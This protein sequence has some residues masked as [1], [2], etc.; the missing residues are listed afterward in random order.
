MDYYTTHQV[1]IVLV[2]L[3]G[4]GKS[5]FATA[6]QSFPP[7][8]VRCNQDDLGDRKAVEAEVHKALGAGKS[9]CVDRTNID[10]SQRRTWIEIGRDYPSVE[11]WCVE[12]DMSKEVCL[13]RLETR[14]D[15]PTI[16]DMQTARKVLDQFSSQYKT[17]CLCEGF[18]LVFRLPPDHEVTPGINL[19]NN[20][21][22]EGGSSH[23]STAENAPAA[24]NTPTSHPEI[25]SLSSVGT[26]LNN[27]ATIA[28]HPYRPKRMDGLPPDPRHA[29]AP[30]GSSYNRGGNRSRGYG[31]RGAGRDDTFGNRTG[32]GFPYSRRGLDPNSNAGGGVGRG[33]GFGSNNIGRGNQTTTSSSS[34]GIP[35]SNIGTGDGR[36]GRGGSRGDAD[37][38]RGGG[39]PS[40]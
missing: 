28:R 4:S 29:S 32:R 27:F 23:T 38:G 12:V 35:N 40:S 10:A 6:L 18:D 25:Y 9:V 34:R 15:H 39:A 11:V 1:L 30:P 19:P 24:S 33:D 2:G 13:Q 20:P 17:P 21:Q 36:R 16:K 26:I 37:L 7:H 5:A 3:I 14:V 22:S 31:A 8:F